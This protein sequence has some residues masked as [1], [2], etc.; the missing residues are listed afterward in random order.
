MTGFCMSNVY[1]FYESKG[2]SSAVDSP[3]ASMLISDHAYLTDNLLNSDEKLLKNES[4][5]PINTFP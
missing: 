4:V 2:L 3:V 5:S 1:T